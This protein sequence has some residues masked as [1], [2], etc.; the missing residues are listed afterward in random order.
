MPDHDRPLQLV[1]FK[2]DLR[3]VDHWPLFEALQQGPVL[4]L[5]I[6]EPEF[7]RQPDASARQWAFCAE[8]LADLRQR[9]E[10]LGQPLVVRVGDAISVLERARQ[11]LGM[12]ALWSHEETGHALSYARDRRVAAWAREHGIPWREIPQFGVIR[13]LRRRQGWAQHWETRMRA[14]LAPEPQSLLRLDGLAPGAIPTSA[15]LQLRSDPCPHRQIGG[16]RE[17]QQTLDTFLR[18]RVNRYAGGISSPLT[19][20]EVCSRLSPYLTWGCLSLREVVQASAPIQGR[21][22]RQF[23]SRLHWHCHFIQK[24]ESEPAIE[25]QDFHPFMRGIRPS[26]PERLQAWAEGRTGLPFVDACMRAL[27]AHGWLN[28]RMRAMLMSVASYHLW[29]P[30]RESGLHLARLFVDYEPGIHWSQCQMQSGSTSINTIRIYNPIKQG[31][32]H[33]PHGVFIRRWCPELAGVPDVVLHEPWRGH[34]DHPRPIVDPK[35]AAREARDRIWEIRRASGFDQL[36]DAI[37]ERHGSRRAGLRPLGKRRS[38]RTLEGAGAQQLT[39]D[40]GAEI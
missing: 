2:R 38:R 24:L 23:R 32:D 3:T 30:W 22:G 26:H 33:D 7:W 28:F 29:L 25:F 9:L 39:L 16:R 21:G 12:A 10:Q 40:L 15:D 11:R 13:G 35:V 14:E 20:F 18:R 37:Q 31:L 6:V 17:G 36:A 27:I 34:P 5:Y 19:A 4:P 1:W 8:A